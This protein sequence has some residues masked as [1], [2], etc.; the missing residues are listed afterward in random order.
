MS[1]KVSKM[2]YHLHILGRFT[3]YSGFK[4]GTVMHQNVIVGYFSYI[5]I[6]L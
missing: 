6:K 1:V 3:A 5:L 2:I 4:C